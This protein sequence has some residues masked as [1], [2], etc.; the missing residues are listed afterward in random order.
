MYTYETRLGI[1][2]T[3]KNGFQTIVSTVDML[4][5]CTQFWMESEPDFAAYLQDNN[6]IMIL[7]FRQLDILRPAQ[8]GEH[9]TVK[10]AI[11]RCKSYFGYRNTAL[12]GNDGLPCAQSWCQGAFFSLDSGRAVNLP[13]AIAQAITYDEKLD[14]EYL[15]HRIR[16]SNEHFRK[17]PAVVITPFD[18]DFNQHVNNARYVQKAC[19]CFPEFSQYNRLRIEYRIP[20]KQ[21]DVMIPHICE[22]D[23][24]SY[25]KLCN[26]QEQP[27]CIIEFSNR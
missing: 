10:T 19:E 6:I 22:A 20:A 21:D 18:V 13:D 24:K 11:Y 4:Q 1:S 14:M 23:S 5:D 9:L 25:V 26:E 7:T 15:P 27:Y 2:Q 8:Y 16:L 3:D 12:Y 17:L